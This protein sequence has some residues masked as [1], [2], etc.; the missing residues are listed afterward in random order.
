M[1]IST[2]TTPPRLINFSDVWIPYFSSIITKNID[3]HEDIRN[4]FVYYKDEVRA[5]NIY[6]RMIATIVRA[7][8]IIEV[9][10]SSSSSFLEKYKKIE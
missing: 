10:K 5:F 6:S 7:N 9:I 2:K 8:D 3:D 4:D 1:H